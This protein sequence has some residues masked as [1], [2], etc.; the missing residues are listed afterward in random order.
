MP[1]GDL[2][3]LF[4]R[5]ISTTSTSGS[6]AI[7]DTSA[8][9]LFLSDTHFGFDVLFFM[10]TMRLALD[11][12]QYVFLVRGNQ[13][14]NVQ[15]TLLSHIPRVEKHVQEPLHVSHIVTKRL[16]LKASICKTLLPASCSRS[17]AEAA[18][19]LVPACIW[20]Y[21]CKDPCCQRLSKAMVG[22]STSMSLEPTAFAMPAVKKFLIHNTGD[23]KNLT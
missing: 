22:T 4:E 13:E 15:M 16:S 17:I 18:W 3:S 9:C 12:V 20:I 10:A 11:D 19:A 2:L 23:E 21:L 6:A 7:R 8:P 1:C 5:Q 14:A